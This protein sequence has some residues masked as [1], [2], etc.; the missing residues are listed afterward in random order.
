MY[1]IKAAT[2]ISDAKNNNWIQETK[3]NIVIINILDIINKQIA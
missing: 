1:L 3:Y 2:K